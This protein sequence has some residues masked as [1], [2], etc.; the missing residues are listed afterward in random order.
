MKE[1]SSGPFMMSSYDRD[2]RIL[3]R[4]AMEVGHK[5]AMVCKFEHGY[6]NAGQ[7]RFVP[8][9]WGVASTSVYPM[10]FRELPK[11]IEHFSEIRIDE[12]KEYE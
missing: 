7:K 10:A 4:K 3:L 5:F 8:G 11:H 1:V 2:D 9:H 6:F 12:I